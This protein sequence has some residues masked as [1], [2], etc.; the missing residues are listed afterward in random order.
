MRK[1]INYKPSRQQATLSMVVGIVFVVM[2][3]LF[4]LPTFA[5]AGPFAILFALLWTG[6]AGYNVVINARFLKNEKTGESENLF[7]GYE[8][9]DTPPASV[10]PEEE[11]HDHIPSTAPSPQ[12]RMEQ[13]ETLKDAGLSTEEEYREKRKEILEDL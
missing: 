13:L 3:L 7:G 10:L 1:N 8:V 2:G 4:I 5:M 6:I 12:K 11:T 9:T